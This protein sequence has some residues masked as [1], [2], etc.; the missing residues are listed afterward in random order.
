MSFIFKIRDIISSIRKVIEE[1]RL[2]E[3]MSVLDYGSGPGGYIGPTLERI[4]KNGTYYAADIHPRAGIHSDRIAGKYR[5]D[6]V[7]FI[8]TNSDTGLKSG[9]VN[10]AYLFDTFHH[11]EDPEKILREIK[12]ILR[13]D[14]SLIFTDHHMKEDSIISDKFLNR[15][16]KLMKKGE[17]TFT[18]SK[19]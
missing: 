19:K 4:G 9:S 7:S 8:N 16:F 11:L 17:H 6:G 1:I 15:H 3:G 2:K 13:K 12:R 10:I 5:H 14:G 18:F